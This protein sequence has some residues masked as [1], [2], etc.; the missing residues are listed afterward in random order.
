M[1]TAVDVRW[2]LNKYRNFSHCDTCKIC[3]DIYRYNIRRSYAKID[4]VF[5]M[6]LKVNLG[7]KI[8]PK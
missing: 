4:C 2:F 5:L 1:F 7:T 6:F 3:S 8:I